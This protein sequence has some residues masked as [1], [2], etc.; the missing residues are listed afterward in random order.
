MTGILFRD[1]A[2]LDVAAGALR[3]G[4]D[5]RV[6]G[7]RIVEVSERPLPAPAAA[8][9]RVVDLDGRVLMPGL[10]ESRWFRAHC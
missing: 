7:E 8:D 6:E 9:V 1:A 2:V 10:R 4:C 3:P 5:V